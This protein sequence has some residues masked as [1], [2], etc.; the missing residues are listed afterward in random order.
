MTAWPLFQNIFILKRPRVAF[1]ADII[2]IVTMFIKIIFKDS[3]KVKRIK[4]YLLKCNLYLYF[5]IY[6]NFLVSGEKNSD[7]SK[8]QGVCHVTHIFFLIFFRHG[9]SV[10]SFIIVGYVRQTLD[11]WAFLGP[12]HQWAA[13]KK[14]IL[15]RVKLLTRLQLGFSQLR[16]HKLRHNFKG[17]M[18]TLC[19][20]IKPETKRHFFLGCQSKCN[21]GKSYE[22]PRIL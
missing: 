1:F 22:W 15:N 16:Q 7:V 8:T 4:N 17:T 2:K 19:C 18:N 21:L 9:M 6:Q 12:P 13:P 20:S 3:G 11:K 14:P 10:P 5:L